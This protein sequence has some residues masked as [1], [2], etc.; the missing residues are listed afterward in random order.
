MHHLWNRVGLAGLWL[1]LLAAAAQGAA[2]LQIP[3]TITK[4]DGTTVRRAE[5]TRAT[6]KGVTYKPFGKPDAA[7]E[8]IP[9]EQVEEVRWGD[10]RQFNLVIRHVDEEEWDRALKA[11]EREVKPE[12]R[13]FWYKPYRV[14]LHGRILLETGK[15]EE[16]LEKLNLVVDKF[17]TSFY[18]LRAIHGK[19]RAHRELD[20]H[21]EAAKTY[22]RLAR[23]GGLWR[24]IG[25]EGEAESY[26]LGE[27]LERAA[28]AYETLVAVSEA[29]LREPGPLKNDL[30][31]VREIYQRA[32][33]GKAMVLIKQGRPAK[34]R[35]WIDQVDEKITS[36][37]SRLRLYMA[38]G[39][40]HFDAG[41]KS[42]DEAE[43]KIHFKKAV[44]AYMRVYILYPD[45]EEL[46]PQAMFGAATASS[47][48]GGSTDRGRARRLYKELIDTYPKSE[49]ADKAK[50]GL[51]ELGGT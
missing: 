2:K 17:P 36:K 21:D 38:L 26:V 51:K 49:F 13:D 43:K 32:L 34:A 27:K 33:V 22:R 47:Y 19:A 4:R 45:A 7:A 41:R 23:H 16:A 1:G 46:R 12:P 24:L 50:T 42:A 40:L 20:Q 6:M 35:R 15:P 11:L 44:L 3:D 48:L 14:L 28:D 10:A 9:L 30:D 18:A 39:E 31:R 37:A 29:V 8:T 25:K 5:V